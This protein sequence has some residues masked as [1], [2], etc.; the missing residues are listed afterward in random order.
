MVAREHLT[1]PESDPSPVRDRQGF[2]SRKNVAWDVQICLFDFKI[3]DS[4]HLVLV[5]CAIQI[6]IIITRDP[7]M[8]LP[9]LSTQE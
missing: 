5:S 4:I 3:Q 1:N 2:A 7:E 9:F 8:I 6:F